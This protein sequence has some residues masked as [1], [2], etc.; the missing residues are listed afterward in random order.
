MSISIPEEKLPAELTA[1]AAVEAAYPQE[2]AR[3]TD[4]LRRGLPVLVEAE[5][6]LTPYLY[7]CVRD[8]LKKETPPRQ[9]L[10][11]DGRPINDMPPPQ[12]GMGLVATILSGRNG[13]IMPSFS[14]LGPKQARELVQGILRPLS[15]RRPSTEHW[16][17]A[18]TQ[19]SGGQC[20]ERCL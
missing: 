7:K 5:K 12:P 2:L 18:P 3:I 17:L 4:S 15:K 14:S 19:E 8:R 11:L 6:E 16:M 13:T 9:F 10:Y 20:T 1:F